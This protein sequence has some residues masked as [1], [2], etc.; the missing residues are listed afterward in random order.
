M[1][2]CSKLIF[3][4]IFAI[5]TLFFNQLAIAHPGRTDANGGHP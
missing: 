2:K 4:T 5:S 3:V 1:K